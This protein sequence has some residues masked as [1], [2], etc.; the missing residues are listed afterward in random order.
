MT[1][2][3][4]RRVIAQLQIALTFKSRCDGNYGEAA[5]YL[6]EKV[7][8]GILDHVTGCCIDTRGDPRPCK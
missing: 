8:L 5:G 3:F 7:A 1:D 2:Y 6:L 4:Y